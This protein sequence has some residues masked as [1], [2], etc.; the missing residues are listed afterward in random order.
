M[1]DDIRTWI[2]GQKRF[3]FPIINQQP[4][5]NASNEF[6]DILTDEQKK[7]IYEDGYF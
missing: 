4:K 1:W 6:I 2:I 3:V 7:N 5:F